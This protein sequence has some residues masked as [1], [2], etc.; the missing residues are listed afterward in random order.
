MRLLVF[1]PL[2]AFAVHRAQA[3]PPTIG[4]TTASN[5]SD[6]VATVITTVVPAIA[7]AINNS[8]V[9]VPISVDPSRP[10]LTPLG[11]GENNFNVSFVPGEYDDEEQRPVGQRF[12][13]KV[14]R[15]E[16]IASQNI[17]LVGATRRRT[18]LEGE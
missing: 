16:T 4:Q 14:R 7:A 9:D 5:R 11:I 1:I 6:V 13:A 3:P 17:G 2:L 8:N 10:S 12:F 18:R 15:L